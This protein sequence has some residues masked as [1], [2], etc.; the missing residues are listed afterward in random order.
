MFIH[1]IIDLLIITWGPSSHTILIGILASRMLSGVLLIIVTLR[2]LS[3]MPHT[4]TDEQAPTPWRPFIKHSSIMWFYTILKSL[5]ERNFLLPICTFA[6]GA[7]IA[8]MFKVAQDGALLFE[9]TIIKTIGHTDTTLLAHVESEVGD[10]KSRGEQALVFEKLV[11]KIAALSIP[12]FGI[13]TFFVVQ[14]FF[15]LQDNEIFHIFLILA[16]SYLLEVLLSPYE[17][18]LEVKLRYGLLLVSYIPYIFILSLLLMRISL[19]GLQNFVLM[20][21]GVR[22]VS[23]ILMVMWVH[24]YYNVRFPLR[25]ASMMLAVTSVSSMLVFYVVRYVGYMGVI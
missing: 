1:T 8:N 14:G 7:G 2:H 10:E 3:V 24:V 20:L 21:Q 6:W 11:R 9:R 4:L 23:S 25:F 15:K 12:L 5:S 17:R 18:V 22:L 16:I 13:L 19:I